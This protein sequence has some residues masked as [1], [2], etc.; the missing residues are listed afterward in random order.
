M[1]VTVQQDFLPELPL[2]YVD[3]VQI[4]QV[5]SNLLTNALEAM[6][7]TGRDFTLQGHRQGMVR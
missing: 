3:R 5:I 6:G 4:G 7:E 1:S 2:V